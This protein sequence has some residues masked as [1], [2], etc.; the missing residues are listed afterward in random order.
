MRRQLT[1][2][3]TQEDSEI[4]EKTRKAYNPAQ[5]KLIK[6]HVTLCR[7]DELLDWNIIQYNLK[8][9]KLK[10]ISISFSSIIRFSENKGVMILSNKNTVAFDNLRKVVL[11]NTIEKPRKQEPHITLMHPRNSNCT[12]AIFEIIKQHSFPST[13]IF[14]TISLIEQ[15]NGG[16]WKTL[17]TFKLD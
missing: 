3:I 14:R 10:S 1:L 12:D 5:H 13:I 2:F 7:E 15:Q 4:I 17:K 8:Q 6:A 16:V 9:I 11:K